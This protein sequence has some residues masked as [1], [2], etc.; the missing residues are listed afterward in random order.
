MATAAPEKTKE[1]ALLPHLGLGDMLMCK[2]LVA[3][4][5]DRVRNGEYARLY[6]VCK[7]RY[8]ASL[9]SLYADLDVA[10]TL[11]S[12]D[13]DFDYAAYRWITDRG[14]QLLKMGDHIDGSDGWKALDPLWTRALYRS[15]DVDPDFIYARFSLSD[16][17]W[18]SDAARD[19]LDKV[20]RLCGGKPYLVVHDDQPRRRLT[21]PAAEADAIESGDLV[22]VHVDDPRI[23]STNIFDYLQVLRGASAVHCLDSCF[24]W[25]LD[26]AGIDVPTTVHAYPR[27]HP[28]EQPY[29]KRLRATYLMKTPEGPLAPAPAGPAGPE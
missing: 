21:L 26:L 3:H 18:R 11:L 8:A 24:A 9:T 22:L 5:A 13:D 23:S 25:L 4:L 29:F 17:L 10:V 27:A 16:D 12:V 1:L 15:C 20:R 7:A 14:I 2:G 6:V 19:M 28:M